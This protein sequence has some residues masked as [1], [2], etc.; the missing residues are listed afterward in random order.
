MLVLM[1]SIADL[2]NWNS[3]SFRLLLSLLTL[4]LCFSYS[5]LILLHLMLDCDLCF[6]DCLSIS[7]SNLHHQH[8]L[9]R[10]DFSD[11]D[12]D[13][14]APPPPPSAPVRF[15]QYYVFSFSLQIFVK[16]TLNKALASD[17]GAGRMILTCAFAAD[18][19]DPLKTTDQTRH[20]GL[21]ATSFAASLGEHQIM[22]ESL[23][24]GIQIKPKSKHIWIDHC[25][26]CDYDDG[27]IDITRESTYIT[28]SR[29]LQRTQAPSAVQSDFEA[30]SKIQIDINRLFRA[31]SKR[32]RRF[33]AACALLNLSLIDENKISIGACGAIP[34][35]ITLLMNGSNR[36]KKDAM[37]TL[38]KLCTVKVNKERAVKGGAVKAVVGLVAAE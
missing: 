8:R 17:L 15:E 31:I 5:S 13:F 7:I 27:L 35:L 25:S 11:F 28:I 37:T 14:E 16:P 29:E 33:R 18:P 2:D 19:D 21:I 12:F 23:D 20:L 38:Y 9:H 10:L 36:G 6:L 32:F 34:P 4:S 3:S 26:L 22:H 1:S 30:I 24:K